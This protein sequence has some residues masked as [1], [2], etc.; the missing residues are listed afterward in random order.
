MPSFDIVSKVDPAELANAVDQVSREIGTRYDFKG[1]SANIERTEN[2][3]TLYADSEFQL[4]Q[5][6]DILYQR[7][8]KRGIDVASFDPQKI[9]T[10]G[11]DRA[12]QVINVKQGIDRELAKKIVRLVKDS[13]LK[14]QAAVQ[15]EELR[16]TGKKRDD[17][18]AVIALLRSA[19]LEQPLQFVNFRD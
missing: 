7:A 10:I 1:T 8:A 6:Q 15:G 12:K 14:V 18:Q 17:L 9:E 3:L 2:L 11:G 16:I 5:V 19:K 13:A 4:K